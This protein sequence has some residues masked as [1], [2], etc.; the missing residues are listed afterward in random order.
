MLK[1]TSAPA[2]R[3]AASFEKR[4]YWKKTAAIGLART[5]IVAVSGAARK[6]RIRR[7]VDSCRRMSAMRPSAAS[8]EKVGKSAIATLTPSTP[9]GIWL[10]WY[11]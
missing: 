11:A 6:M 8:R 7:L 9:T 1:K 4:P 2:V 3:S 5:I 10:S